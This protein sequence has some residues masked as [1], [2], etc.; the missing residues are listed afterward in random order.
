MSAYSNMPVA[1]VTPVAWPVN[2]RNR[3]IIK[4][5]LI[6]AGVLFGLLLGLLSLLLVSFDTGSVGLVVGIILAVLPVPVYVAL[7][8]WV[9][10]YEPEPLWML[11]MAFFWGAF[12]AGFVALIINSI[13]MVIAGK[14]IGTVISAPLVEESS[15]AAVLLL[16][17]WWKKDEFDDVLDGIIYAT[18]VGLGFA[19]AENVGYY[20][21]ALL[22]GAVVGTFIIRG[23]IAPFSHPLFTSMTGIG[24]GLAA[25]SKNTLVKIVA[26]ILGLGMAILLHFLNNLSATY[27]LWLPA[28]VVIMVPAFICLLAAILF[29]LRREGRI[30]RQHLQSD[31]ASGLLT[32][33]DLDC[34]CS[35]PKRMSASFQ[36]LRRGGVGAWRTRMK[37]HDM[38]SELAFCRNR[39]ALRQTAQG[40]APNSQEAMYAQALRDLQ[41]KLR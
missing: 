41:T 28:F 25:Q 17:F 3:R 16:F 21:R 39:A 9:D 27:R 32:Q 38:A 23:V 4:W 18:M 2:Q 15:K 8:V 12:I 20:G 26:P 19:M 22:Q 11:A 14:D 13:V 31:L 7:A 24:L 33:Q 35:V 36:A 6:T 1:P 40:A 10:R 34:L 30:V 29:A 5:A 37:F